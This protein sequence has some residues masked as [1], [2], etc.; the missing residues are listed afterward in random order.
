MTL[1]LLSK[2]GRTLIYSTELET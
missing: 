1:Y 2:H